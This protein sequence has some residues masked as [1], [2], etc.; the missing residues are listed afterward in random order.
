[1]LVFSQ[2]LGLP[3]DRK[4][5]IVAKS[6]LIVQSKTSR[7]VARPCQC[8]KEPGVLGSRG[9]HWASAVWAWDGAGGCQ[10]C[11]EAHHAAKSQNESN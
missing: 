5:T 3:E 10:E 2:M 4:T 8:P 6:V 1:M 7:R 9:R 11:V